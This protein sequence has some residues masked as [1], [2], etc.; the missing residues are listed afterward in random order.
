M[1]VRDLHPDCSGRGQQLY[2]TLPAVSL[3]DGREIVT[4]GPDDVHRLIAEGHLGPPPESRRPGGVWRA[5]AAMLSCGL[6]W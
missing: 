5:A 2:G 3:R 1:C 6:P 4:N